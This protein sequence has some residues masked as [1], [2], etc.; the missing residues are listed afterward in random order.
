MAAL[1]MRTIRRRAVELTIGL[2]V[3]VALP[4]CGGGGGASEP[5]ESAQVGPDAEVIAVTKADL[6]D[7]LGLCPYSGTMSSFLR[8]IGEISEEARN[9]SAVT[10]SE[11]QAA[12]AVEGFVTVHTGL[13]VACRFLVSGPPPGGHDHGSFRRSVTSS[14]FQFE[15]EAAAEAAYSKDILQQSGLRDQPGAVVGADTGLGQNAVVLSNENAVPKAFTAVWQNGRFY[16]SLRIENL[17][18]A[19][20]DAAA[21]AQHRRAG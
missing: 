20:A 11:L 8:G 3:V 2:A 6:P 15:D 21:A 14:V 10:W 9:S 17:S 19:E 16:L 5:S 7:D 4:G 12:G 18:R 1:C 13:P